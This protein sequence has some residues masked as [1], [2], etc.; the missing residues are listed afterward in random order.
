MIL[1]NARLLP[2]L[3]EGYTGEEADI[4]I[5]D[6]KIEKILPSSKKAEGD[7][8][9][10][11]EE[12]DLID[13]GGAYVLP[14][15]M[16]LHMHM[17]FATDNFEKLAMQ[18]PA[19][20]VISC[21]SYA[22]TLLSWGYTTIRDMGNPDYMGVDIRNA[23]E[24]GKI[25]GP[26]IFTAGRCM[27]PYAKGNDTFPN[28]YYEVNSPQEVRT[29]CRY[30]NA[31]GV[32]WLKYMATGSVANRTG[33]PGAMITTQE[34]LDALEAG[35]EETG[36]H[37]A[38]HCH[39]TEG[40][41]ACVR[42]GIRTIEH[43]S[44]V[45]DECI[46]EILKKGSRSCLIPTLTPVVGI[47]NEFAEGG[48][49]NYMTEKIEQCYRAAGGLVQAQRAGILLGWG[50]DTSRTSFQKNPGFEFIARKQAGFTNREILEQA[51]INSAKVLGLEESLGTICEGKKADLI[52]VDGNPMDDITVMTRKPALVIRE[53][54]RYS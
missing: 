50:T 15:L 47:H 21:I 12:T 20:N 43:A 14:G 6:G 8:K 3:T 41:L 25:E 46:E 18:R 16:D 39:G 48:E 40:I 51:T 29:A 36:L 35:A 28:L 10:G 22:Q 30:E 19:Q 38:V 23:V 44:F 27:S 4:V 32:D 1:R 33:V 37:A 49:K 42:A 13:L 17:Y 52:A 26:R 24:E 5:R 2:F 34:E 31:R 9:S 11:Q 54:K 53:G 45:T 7:T